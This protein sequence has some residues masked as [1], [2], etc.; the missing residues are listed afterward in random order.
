[1]DDLTRS[2]MQRRK[3]A[4]ELASCSGWTDWALPKLRKIIQELEASILSDDSLTAEMMLRKKDAL[5]TLKKDF[6]GGLYA[7]AE[8]SFQIPA[9]TVKNADDLAVYMPDPTEIKATLE[10]LEYRPVPPD[11]APQQGQPIEETTDY[12]PFGGDPRPLRRAGKPETKP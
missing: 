8:G 4:V 7:E 11:D 9:P 1:M 5:R 3:L 10:N 12:S 2:I 6:L